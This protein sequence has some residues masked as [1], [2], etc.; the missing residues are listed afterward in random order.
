[1]RWFPVSTNPAPRTPVAACAASATSWIEK[2]KARRRSERRRIWSWRSS[3]PKTL[4]LATPCTARRRG[5]SVHCA[6]ERSSI[7]V[8]FSERRP[9]LRRSIVAEV[10]GVSFGGWTPAGSCPAAFDELFRENLAR[11]VDVRARL[12]D[13]GDDRET[14]DRLAAERVEAAGAVERGFDGAGDEELDLLGGEPGGLRLDGDLG[15]ANSGEDVELRVRG[16]EAAVGEDGGREHDDDG[17]VAQREADEGAQHAAASRS[18]APRPDPHSSSP[19][20]PAAARISVERRLCAPSTTIDGSSRIAGPTA[21]QP[22]GSGWSSRSSRR[23]NVPFVLPGVD[24]GLFPR[25]E[26]PRAPRH[27][28][29]LDG[30]GTALD[31]GGDRLARTQARGARDAEQE[32]DALGFRRRREGDEGP[33]EDAVRGARRDDLRAARVLHAL[34]DREL[35]ADERGLEECRPQDRRSGLDLFPRP[36]RD[37]HDLGRRGELQRVLRRR[38]AARERPVEDGESLLRALD[39]RRARRRA[40]FGLLERAVGDALPLR[41]QRAGARE[42]ALRDL[43]RSGGFLARAFRVGGADGEVGPLER[44]EAGLDPA[45]VEGGRRL[46]DLGPAFPRADGPATGARTSNVRE[47][48]ETTRP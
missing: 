9:I 3:P 33:V 41:V 7:G 20:P 10:R 30:L 5:R 4:T 16:H 24:P 34:A 27:D 2:S 31:P 25:G 38:P 18:V 32:R 22:S 35:D 47:G 23:T 6:K 12:E 37:L 8:S 21:S 19:P 11:E 44:R 29:A 1:M 26:R 46:A 17:A 42:L 15:G 39:A 40:R 43:E 48:S 14:L 45:E 28:E 13:R 36:C